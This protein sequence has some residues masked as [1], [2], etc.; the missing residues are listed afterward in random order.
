MMKSD[1]LGTVNSACFQGEVLEM[2]DNFTGRDIT[3][4]VSV[5]ALAYIPGHTYMHTY[6][7]TAISK[8]GIAVLVTIS[9]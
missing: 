2:D 5:H 8:L 4:P 7:H 3:L 6:M 9:W 1:V